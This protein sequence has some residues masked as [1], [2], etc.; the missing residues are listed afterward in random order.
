MSDDR[1]EYAS[2]MAILY[3]PYLLA[4]LTNGDWDIKTE[5]AASLSD[6]ITPIPAAYNSHLISLSQESG[7]ST[8][9]LTN[10][11]HS[12]TMEKF[13]ESGTDSSLNAKFRLVLKDSTS[14]WF[15]NPKDFI[16]K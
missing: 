11:N 16:G 10:S 9:V 14:S 1:P 8:L 12:I 6:Y 7:D 15:S 4:G 5:S 3:G 2:I 13:P